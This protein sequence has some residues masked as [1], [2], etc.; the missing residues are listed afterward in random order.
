MLAAVAA[1]G[2]PAHAEQY[3]VKPV[4]VV[5]PAPPGGLSDV[6]ARSLSQHLGERLGQPFLVENRAGANGTIGSDHVAK[7]A[8]DG[9]T[10]LVFPSLFV[11]TPLLM[12]NVPYDVVKDFTPV[13]NLGTVPLVLVSNPAVPVRSLREFIALAKAT[14]GKYTFATSGVGSVGHLTEERIQREAGFQILIAHYK[15][16]APAVIDLMGG[17]VSAM[18]DPVPNFIEQ[19]KSGKL[20]ALAVTS[21]E[22]VGLMPDV[23]T[24]AEAGLP[25]IEI[26]SW[27]GMWGPARL[28]RHVVAVLNREIAEAVKSSKVTER[29]IAQGMVP[30]GSKSEDFA[31]FMTAEIAKYSQ[32]IKD[33]NIKAED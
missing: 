11:I 28:P 33:A 3:P 27:Y 5:V 19:V 15:G 14:P 6:V 2:E 4:R 7:S 24:L 23:P 31:A 13:S 1:W 29:L 8:A 32:I 26:G 9:H 10:L 21:R 18:I 30:V 22:R 20:K 17:R 16:A 12:K 25:G